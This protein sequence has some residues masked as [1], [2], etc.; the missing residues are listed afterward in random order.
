MTPRCSVVTVSPLKAT[1]VC[2]PFS[3][4]SESPMRCSISILVLSRVSLTLIYLINI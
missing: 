2:L 3:S 1:L 4:C